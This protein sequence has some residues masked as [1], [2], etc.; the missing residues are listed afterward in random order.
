[1]ENGVKYKKNTNKTKTQ[2]ILMLEKIIEEMGHIA[3]KRKKVVD[4][5]VNYNQSIEILNSIPKEKT[6][7]EVTQVLGDVAVFR[8]DISSADIKDIIT[9]RFSPTIKNMTYFIGRY[10]IHSN[11]YFEMHEINASQSLNPDGYADAHI[12]IKYILQNQNPR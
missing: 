1:M 8:P 6:K 3:A 4:R 9:K 2:K 10:C 7:I 11:H 12:K 5:E